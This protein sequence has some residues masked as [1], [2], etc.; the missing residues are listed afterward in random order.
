MSRSSDTAF[1][2]RRLQVAAAVAREG[3]VRRAS[4]TLNLSQPAVSQAVANLES[5]LGEPLFERSSAGMFVTPSGALFMAR[6]RRVIGY[7]RSGEQEAAGGR[8]SDAP[9]LH[10][11]ATTVQWRA[12]LAV[13]EHGGYA[14]AARELG[15]SQPGVHRAARDL[16]RLCG[17]PLFRAGASG[18][19]PTAEALA[20]ARW[21]GLALREIEQ[22][23][24]E[25][26]ERRG[27]ADGTVA[28]GSLPLAR[29]RIVPTAVTRLLADRPD[30]R[31]RIIDGPYAELLDG[32][33]HGR[34]DL[35]LGA[36]RLPAPAPGLRQEA[37][38]VEPLSIVVRAGH[39]ILANPPRSVAALAE[40]E[41]IAPNDRTP[42]RAQF[43]ALFRQHGTEPPRRVVECSSLVATRGLL[44]QSDRAALLSA[45]QVPSLGGELAIAPILLPG[46]ER[47]IGV[48]TRD[49]WAP[50][51]TQARFLDLVREVA[52][53][54]APG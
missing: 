16:E 5:A 34:I 9:P 13:V 8:V 33:L 43:T 38:F 41:W 46:T 25:L 1:S 11:L 29:T 22:G 28:I 20:L 4:A 19:E 18:A 14:A 21:A 30:A 51:A 36:L 17:R 2:F 35:I 27:F 48:C 15:V 10:R 12:F 37:L 7:L 3:G 39:P 6:V 32:L 40:L 54:V 44:L 31:V 52:G 24:E 42:A 26:R 53:E 50:T 23:V 47:S 45:S 49:D